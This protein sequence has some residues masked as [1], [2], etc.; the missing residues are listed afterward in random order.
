MEDLEVR[1]RS[2][3]S[4]ANGGE[5]RVEVSTFVVGRD[6]RRSAEF[7]GE[8]VRTDHPPVERGDVG[9]VDDRSDVPAGALDTV[10]LLARSVS[11]SRG[12]GAAQSNEEGRSFPWVL[13]HQPLSDDERIDTVRASRSVGRSV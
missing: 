6:G 2:Y 7:S 12:K 9:V 1:S 5:S 4:G 13:L 11:R 8:L 10:I 3:R